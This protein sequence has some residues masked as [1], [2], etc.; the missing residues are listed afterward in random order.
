MVRVISEHMDPVVLAAAG[1]DVWTFLAE[2]A[3]LW[4]ASFFLAHGVRVGFHKME[5]GDFVVTGYGVPHSGFSAGTNVA[6]AVN[7]ACT[8]WLAHAIEHEA[9]WRGKIGM[10]IPFEKLLVLSALKLAAGKWWFGDAKA[11]E[12]CDPAEFRRDLRVMTSFLTEYLDC[13]L[14]YMRTDSHPA[15]KG[16]NAVVVDLKAA[17]HAVKQFVTDIAIKP[18]GH[19]LVLPNEKDGVVTDYSVD[20]AACPHCGTVVWM[21]LVVCPACIDQLGDGAGP[22]APICCWRCAPT[23]Y[24]DLHYRPEQASGKEPH[25]VGCHAPLV[26]QRLSNGRVYSLVEEL[27]TIGDMG[28]D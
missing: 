6:S 10:L 12:A 8:G 2:K 9:R 1:G 15:W 18:A 21:S 26:V 11:Y 24:D 22:S 14:A 17:P 25:L 7:L 27:K 20:G 3:V 23:K 16:E 19:G 28:S 5:V 4:P 13:I